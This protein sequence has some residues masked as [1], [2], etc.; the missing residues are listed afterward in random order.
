M[1]LAML[2]SCSTAS[3]ATR[4]QR[5]AET[6]ALVGE[7]LEKHDFKIYVSYMSPQRYPSRDIT[8]DYYVKVGDGRLISNLPYFGQAQVPTMTYPAQGLNF[9]LPIKSFSENYNEAKLR[10]D[11]KIHVSNDEDSYEYVISLFDNGT[12]DIMVRPQ[13]CDYVRFSGEIEM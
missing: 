8:S 9:D 1:C 6:A 7:R 12:A 5:Q 3:T 13:K 10:T 2:Q 4:S 11:M